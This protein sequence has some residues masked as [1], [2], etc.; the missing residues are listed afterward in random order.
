MSETTTT[1]PEEFLAALGKL[2]DDSLAERMR[3]MVSELRRR[4]FEREWS[5]PWMEPALKLYAANGNL[6]LTCR[7]L[8]ADGVDVS[9]R[10]VQR[11]IKADADFRRAWD[12]AKEEATDLLRA[13]VHRRATG[14]DDPIVY[15]GRVQQIE[16]PDNPG[17]MIP[18][19]VRKYDTTLLIFLLKSLDHSFRDRVEHVGKGGGPI[20]T[21]ST[22]N[23]VKLP[24]NGRGDREP[25]G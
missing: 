11:H 4:G 25:P 2:D 10:T 13:E 24:D 18:A 1:P 14:Y 22:V 19:T 9:R 5:E 20:Q 8:N 23:V 3:A 7:I 21:E 16:D 15:Q 6:S 17:N 12:E